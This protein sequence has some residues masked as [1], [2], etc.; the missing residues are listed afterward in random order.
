[1]DPFM[2]CNPIHVDDEQIDMEL[3]EIWDIQRKRSKNLRAKAGQNRPGRMQLLKGNNNRRGFSLSR[4]RSRSKD[5]GGR[6]TVMGRTTSGGRGGR[7]ISRERGRERSRSPWGRKKDRKV[8][9]NKYVEKIETAPKRLGGRGRSRERSQPRFV[10][11]SSFDSRGSRGRVRSVTGIKPQRS[12]SWS[13]GRKKVQRAQS[14]KFGVV[15]VRSRSKERRRGFSSERREPRG[16][17]G[18]FA[19]RDRRDEYDDDSWSSEETNRDGG[20]FGFGY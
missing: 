5:R 4:G 3:E 7:S 17:G 16:G 12:R 6:N 8:S 13:L 14:E 19:R 18:F 15:R 9:I 11:S 10:R 2:C 20:F 1:M